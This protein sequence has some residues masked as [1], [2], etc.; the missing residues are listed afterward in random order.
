MGSRAPAFRDVQVLAVEEWSGSRGGGEP[1]PCWPAKLA[2]TIKTRQ[3]SLT[4]QSTGDGVRRA[5]LRCGGVPALSV[6]GPPGSRAASYLL[7][8]RRWHRREGRLLR[9]R[10]ERIESNVD[11]R[12]CV[13]YTAR[14]SAIMMSPLR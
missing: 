10:F 2:L 12:R 7:D 14:T 9:L 11:V 13:L 5:D 6:D 4:R 1:P 3:R 8:R